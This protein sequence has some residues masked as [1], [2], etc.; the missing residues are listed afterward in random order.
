MKSF[1]L[2]IILSFYLNFSIA[3]GTS[4][5]SI[6]KSTY[7]LT[8]DPYLNIKDWQ[9]RLPKPIQFEIGSATL[10]KKY[11]KMLDS[12]ALY[13][14]QNKGYTMIRVESHVIQAL[15]MESASKLSEAQAEAIAIYLVKNCKIDCRRLIVVGC[16]SKYAG[17]MGIINDEVRFT[18]CAIDSRLQGN[19]DFKLGCN[20]TFRHCAK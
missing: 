11:H 19:R 20:P 14:N 10:D 12:F 15:T 4:L 5:D 13:L 18:L 9:L 8:I 16:G 17:Q 7:N 1:Y 6:Q 2:F 3:W